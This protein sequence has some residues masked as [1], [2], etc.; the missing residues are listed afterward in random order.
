MSTN[1]QYYKQ[2][3][4]D[5][6]MVAKIKEAEMRISGTAVNYIP[7]SLL[8]NGKDLLG[9]I[10]DGDIIALIT[11]KKGLEISHVGIAVWKNGKLHLLNASSLKHKVILDTQTLYEY[12]KTRK[13]Q[14]GI[15]VIRVY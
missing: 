9:D 7:K 3:K 5:T 6:A 11:N 1:P 15:R 4:N 12:Q 8:N 2:L 10:K 13:S 14:L